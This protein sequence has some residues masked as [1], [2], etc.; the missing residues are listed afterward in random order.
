MKNAV[1]LHGWGNNSKDN[2]FPWL[3]NELEKRGWSVWVPDLPNTDRPDVHNWDPYILNNF[4]INKDTVL[5]GHSAGAVEV[6]SIL[7]QIKTKVKKA[8]LVAGFTDLLKKDKIEEELMGLFRRPFNWQKIK[9]KAD[10]IIL[11]HSD[12]DPFVPLKHGV[13]LKQKLQAKLILLKGQ[14]HFSVSTG[15]EKF[16]KLPIILEILGEK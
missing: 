6:L 10:K 7:G 9:K 2:W 15:G 14:K 5:I 3:K 13:I 16:R 12:D 8:I 11:I 4:D 1:I